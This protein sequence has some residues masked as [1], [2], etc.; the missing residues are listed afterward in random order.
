LGS[1]GNVTGVLTPPEQ[2]KTRCSRKQLVLRHRPRGDVPTRLAQEAEGSRCYR[3][4]VINPD[5]I[6]EGASRGRRA[7]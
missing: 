4:R 1:G 7:R 6:S 3:N 5:W 2:G